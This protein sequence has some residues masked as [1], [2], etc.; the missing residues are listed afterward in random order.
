MIIFITDLLVASFLLMFLGLVLNNAYS[1]IIGV[2]VLIA[3]F[4][5][6]II[7]DPPKLIP[8]NNPNSFESICHG[9]GGKVAYNYRSTTL[10]YKEGKVIDVKE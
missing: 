1:V 4:V 5:L 7:I 8:P 6:M 2:V 3:D 10:C 9:N